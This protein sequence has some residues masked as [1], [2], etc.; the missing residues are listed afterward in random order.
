MA[1]TT[2]IPTVDCRLPRAETPSAAPVSGETSHSFYNYT[3]T[4]IFDYDSGLFGCDYYYEY[5]Y[6]SGSTDTVNSTFTPCTPLDRAKN[7]LP[8]ST[9]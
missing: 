9:L 1:L 5:E 8:L 7:T 2:P 4:Y 6:Y 3:N